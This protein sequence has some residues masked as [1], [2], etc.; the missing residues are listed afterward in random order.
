MCRGHCECVP[1]LLLTFHT[2][3]TMKEINGGLFRGVHGKGVG[4]RNLQAAHLGRGIQGTSFRPGP[5]L[6][7][8]RGS[9]T[10]NTEP[11][12]YIPWGTR[13]GQEVTCHHRGGG[14]AGDLG[15]W[16]SNGLFLVREHVL[17]HTW[18]LSG[19][20]WFAKLV[21]MG[22]LQSAPTFWDSRAVL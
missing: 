18:P 12:E 9:G 22:L 21:F 8:C 5:G 19:S 10:R 11:P 7:N 4:P 3:I 17:F 2:S 14:I 15:R 1:F 13:E 16:G 20:L 6:R